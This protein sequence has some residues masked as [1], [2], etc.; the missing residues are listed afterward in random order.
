MPSVPDVIKHIVCEMSDRIFRLKE[1]VKGTDTPGALTEFKN[2][3]SS[4]YIRA[5]IHHNCMNPKHPYWKKYIGLKREVSIWMACLFSLKRSTA[6]IGLQPVLVEYAARTNSHSVSSV[7]VHNRSVL[8]GQYLK[9]KKGKQKYLHVARISKERRLDEEQ[10]A[11]KQ[12]LAM[13]G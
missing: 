11:A 3:T 13:A 9:T 6:S 2:D 8:L 1:E 12:Q 5:N 10:K 7:L 4:G